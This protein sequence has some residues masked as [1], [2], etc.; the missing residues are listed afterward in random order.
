MA[1]FALSALALTA[2]NGDE[3][4]EQPDGSADTDTGFDFDTDYPYDLDAGLRCDGGVDLMQPSPDGVGEIPTG[5]ER[6]PGDSAHRYAP[7]QCTITALIG[8]GCAE[9][10]C[11]GCAPDQLCAEI[12]G[13]EDIYCGCLKPCASD[14]DCATGE[15]CVCDNAGSEATQCVPAQCRT[16]EDCGGFECG[17]SWKPMGGGLRQLAC[18]S[19]A[20]DCYG[21]E[22]CDDDELCCYSDDYMQWECATAV[23]D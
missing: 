18:R 9:E 5:V 2:C 21:A 16:D 8:N 3:A 12:S 14:A 13:S 7:V 17:L 11:L 10:D 6:C 1:L 15:A 20:D 23:W 4:D 19:A 22:Q